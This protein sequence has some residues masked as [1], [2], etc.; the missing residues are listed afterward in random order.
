MTLL[1]NYNEQNNLRLDSKQYLANKNRL[2]VIKQYAQDFPLHWHNFFELEI[3]LDGDATQILN[4]KEYKIS[5]GSVY[6]L[7][8][9]DYHKIMP[10]SGKILLW[11]VMFD[12]S[13]LSFKQLCDLTS[14]KFCF[15]FNICE[16]D[17]EQVDK[18]MQL[19][20]EE[21]NYQGET[22]AKELFYSLLCLL[23]RNAPQNSNI[24]TVNHNDIQRAIIYLETHFRENLTLDILAS[25]V[26]FHPVY[27]S[28]LFKKFTGVTFV[29]RLNQLR[30]SYA[31][32]LLKQGLTVTEACFNCGFNSLSNF[33]H[34]FKKTTGFTPSEFKKQ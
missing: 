3:V 6:L 31:K 14:S 25:H 27:L 10:S 8:P 9:T 32:N 15:P 33:Q 11:N 4:G 7:S 1:E 26:G 13:M 2:R 12:E 5:R 18:L 23:L 19:L 20:V 22:C 21:Y 30:I 16:K 17:L 24:S 29:Q 28:K 34:T